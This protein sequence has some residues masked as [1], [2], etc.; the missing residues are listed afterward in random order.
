MNITVKLYWA[1]CG[2][3]DVDSHFF[4]NK[5]NLCSYKMLTSAKLH[6]K[7]GLQERMLGYL[8]YIEMRNLKEFGV[9]LISNIV[10]AVAWNF[11]C[12]QKFEQEICRKKK[13]RKIV[14]SWK[15]CPLLLAPFS[16]KKLWVNR[17]LDNLSICRSVCGSVF[18]EVSKAVHYFPVTFSL[19]DTV[20][21]YYSSIKIILYHLFDIHLKTVFVGFETR[22]TFFS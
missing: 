21:R 2:I 17:I 18:P 12:T 14:L 9:N 8:R 11:L 4:A 16:H 15:W 19:A 13:G 20:L 22:N 10:C 5:N 6:K 3:Y 1:S 7:I